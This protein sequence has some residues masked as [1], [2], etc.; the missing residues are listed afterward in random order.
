MKG[1]MGCPLLEFV[2]EMGIEEG[3]R[4]SGT[5]M[6]VVW[7]GERARL[8]V[9]GDKRAVGLMEGLREGNSMF[10][11][12]GRVGSMAAPRVDWVAGESEN[13]SGAVGEKVAA[14]VVGL[15]AESML[16]ASD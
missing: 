11:A 5:E 9:L 14:A 8:R 4:E 6:I 12:V 7:G 16:A 3:E 15:T 1:G 13:A 10:T 2:G